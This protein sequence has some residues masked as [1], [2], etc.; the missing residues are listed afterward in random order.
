[1]YSY[2]ITLKYKLLVYFEAYIYKYIM[3][4]RTKLKSLLKL[5]P[6]GAVLTTP[7]LH[8]LGYSDDQLAKYKQS[9]WLGAVGHGAYFRTDDGPPAIEAGIAAMRT[10]LGLMLH[11]GGRSALEH[12]SSTNQVPFRQVSTLYGAPGTRLPKWFRTFEWSAPHYYYTTNLFNGDEE[13]AITW[14]TDY[15]RSP[16]AFPCSTRERAMLER[17]LPVKDEVDLEDRLNDMYLQSEFSPAVVQALLEK[18]TSVKV[19]RVFLFL[20]DQAQQPWFTKLDLSRIN[21]GSGIRQIARRDGMVNKRFKI[22]VER[23]IPFA[24]IP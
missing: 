1:M 9:D 18:C 24:D 3:V 12:T 22:T 5:W 7:H 8:K 14:E 23:P 6:R 17:L 2:I 10:Q 13:S 16:I 4:T 15:S 20:A 21:L 19:K 11:V